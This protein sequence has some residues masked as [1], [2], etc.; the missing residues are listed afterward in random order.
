MTAFHEAERLEVS[1]FYLPSHPGGLNYNYNY[2]ST[3]PSPGAQKELQWHALHIVLLSVTPRA[4]PS[5]SHS[6]SQQIQQ[7]CCWE[8]KRQTINCT[9]IIRAILWESISLI[10]LDQS[11]SLTV[12]RA[13]RWIPKRVRTS[14]SAVLTAVP[15]RTG[16]TENSEWTMPGRL[17]MSSVLW[18]VL[19]GAEVRVL[20]KQ[21]SEDYLEY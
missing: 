19:R 4:E 17:E 7:L 13:G 20:P 3:A 10:A 1:V 12:S 18:C 21:R 16:W 5:I 9:R 2:N 6:C 15:L 11:R 14:K 8:N